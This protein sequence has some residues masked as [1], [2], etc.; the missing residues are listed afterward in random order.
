MTQ[1]SAEETGY[2]F[3]SNEGAD[4]IA[5]IDPYRAYQVIK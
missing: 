5:V 2:V 3:V 1:A 4:N